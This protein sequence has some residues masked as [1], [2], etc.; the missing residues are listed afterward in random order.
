MG[1][2]DG[3]LF[4]T[5]LDGTLTL[6]GGDRISDENKQA[7]RYFQ[8]EGGL[9]SVAT[10]RAPGF[11]KQFESVFKP[12]API[13]SVNGTLI[14]S[15]DGETKLKEYALGDDIKPVLRFLLE[16]GY[17]EAVHVAH[18]DGHSSTLSSGSI[19]E[20]AEYYFSL[21]KPWYKVL[22]HQSVESTFRLIRELNE[23]FG[24]AFEYNSSYP[25]G[26]EIHKKGSGKGVCMDWIKHNAGLGI[27]ETIA[28]GDYDN[29]LDMIRRATYGY[30]VRNAKA[31]VK[32]AA[33]Y[34]TV[35]NEES[36]IAH[37]V[38]DI[39]AICRRRNSQ[40]PCQ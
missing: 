19:D 24:D 35:S 40:K 14:C 39:E 5:D 1:L 27:K 11:I 16:C 21:S 12:N 33:K 38:S 3:F 10:G 15:P 8:S 32:A 9:F 18:T 17:V 6:P 25:M 2:F 31:S 30:A 34:I 36:A 26:I 7:I 4:L 37:I 23:L 20:K 13:V 22:A 28:V 29:D